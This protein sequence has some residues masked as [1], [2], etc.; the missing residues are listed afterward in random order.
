MTLKSPPVQS[1]VRCGTLRVK[2]FLHTACRVCGARARL[3]YVRLN[4]GRQSVTASCLLGSF[5]FSHNSISEVPHR[6]WRSGPWRVGRGRGQVLPRQTGY[7]IRVSSWSRFVLGDIIMR[8]NTNRSFWCFSS[9]L[10]SVTINM[11]ALNLT[12]GLFS[13][14]TPYL[15]LMHE[16]VARTQSHVS[17]DAHMPENVGKWPCFWV[18]S[19]TC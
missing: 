7:R 5:L 15:Q 17:Y 2:N 10:R 12:W 1:L 18:I 4:A 6:G 13:H 11:E 16:P 9:L 14:W 19:S 3:P 8:T